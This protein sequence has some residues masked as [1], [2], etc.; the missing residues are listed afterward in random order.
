MPC[1]CVYVGLGSNLDNPASQLDQAFT[2]LRAIAI[3]G[4]IQHSSL[5][6]SKAVG[7]P[8]PDYINAVA[9]L[10]TQLQPLE[11]LDA[12]QRLEAEQGRVRTVH[13]GP[14]T[15]DL[16]VLLIDDLQLDHPRLKIPHPFLRQ[17]NFVLVPLL[18]LDPNLRLPDGDTVS[19]LVQQVGTAGLTRFAPN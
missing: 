18:E 1:R 2:A 11:M 13:W 10:E 17:R 19:D 9:R 5:Y 12:L 3:D 15:L 7:P 6:R 14:R 16:D 8:Q 4:R